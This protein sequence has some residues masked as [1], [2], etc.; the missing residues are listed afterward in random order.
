M[1]PVA[2][3]STATSSGHRR[4]APFELETDAL[5]YGPEEDFCRLRLHMNLP[6]EALVTSQLSIAWT[7]RATGK[8]VYRELFNYFYA[9]PMTVAVSL[10]LF[11]PGVYDL[12]AHADRRGRQGAGAPAV[13]DHPPARPG[14]QA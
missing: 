12:E 10:A 9:D 7:R 1:C 3:W 4:Q 13:G 5:A 8:Q 14:A 2:R 11:P 6:P